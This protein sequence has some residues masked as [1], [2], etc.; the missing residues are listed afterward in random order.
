MLCVQQKKFLSSLAA[1]RQLCA[2]GGEWRRVGAVMQCGR[3]KTRQASKLVE[4][5]L[6]V[7]S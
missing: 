7:E 2:D 5:E 3:S 4:L 1:L 6:R